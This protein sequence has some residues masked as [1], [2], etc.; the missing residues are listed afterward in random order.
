MFFASAETNLQFE[1]LEIEQCEEY[2]SL[3]APPL[4]ILEK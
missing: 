4:K 3:E 1:K 2:I